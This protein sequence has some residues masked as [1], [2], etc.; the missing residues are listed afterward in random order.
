V[1]SNVRKSD[2]LRTGGVSLLSLEVIEARLRQHYKAQ[3]LSDS[4]FKNCWA[5]V[6]H[7]GVHPQLATLSDVEKVVLRVEKNSTRRYYATI[8]KIVFQYMNKLQLITNDPTTDLARPRAARALPKPLTD[9]EAMFLMA[10]AKSPMRQWI[11]LGCMAGLRA[12]EISNLCGSDLSLTDEGYIL[13]VRGK[14]GTVLTVPAHPMVV[15][16]IQEAKTLGRLWDVTP[17]RV[18]QRAAD[19]MRRLGVDR[20]LHCA[21]HYFATSALKASGGDLLVVRDLMRH[22]S[23]ATTQVYTQLAVERPRSV[24]GLLPTPKSA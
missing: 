19:E 20:T 5:V 9:K 6:R 15:E 24:I 22:T 14:G 16:V 4:H 1:K 17:I 10:N 21:R 13:E 8:L 2:L 11:I 18:T 12:M 23:V 3:G 7:L